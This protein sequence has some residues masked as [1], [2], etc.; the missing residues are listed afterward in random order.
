MSDSK[1]PKSKERLEI[2]ARTS[3]GFE[4]AESDLSL[5]GPGDFFGERQSGELTFKFADI[6]DMEL[7]EKTGQAAKHLMNKQRITKE[8][9][10]AIDHFFQKTMD[11]KTFN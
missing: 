10:E 4:I 7:I 2:M 11:G 3:D 1:S 6:T 8:I 9:E 5:R